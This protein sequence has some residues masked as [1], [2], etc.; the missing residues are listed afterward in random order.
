MRL[1]AILHGGRSTRMG[2]DKAH[3]VVDG[4]AMIDRARAVVAAVC[5]RVVVVGGAHADVADAVSADDAGSAFAGV[6]AAVEFAAGVGAAAVVVVPVDM[7]LLTPGL[8]RRLFDEDDDVS[9]AGHPLP[10]VVQATSA[11]RLRALFDGGARKLSSC[12]R[13]T[14]DVPIDVPAWRLMNVNAPDDVVAAEAAL[15]ASPR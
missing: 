14:V 13:R 1:G 11:P 4:V 10:L 3:V 12:A 6:V 5:D 2:R 15:R 7:P 8:L 9:F